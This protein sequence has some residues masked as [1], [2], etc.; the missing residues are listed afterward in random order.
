MHCLNLHGEAAGHFSIH[1]EDDISLGDHIQMSIS[2]PLLTELALAVLG[3]AESGL[4]KRE[5]PSNESVKPL[6]CHCGI[7]HACAAEYVACT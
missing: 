1:L 3:R 5:E 4:R 6:L 2:V 7:A